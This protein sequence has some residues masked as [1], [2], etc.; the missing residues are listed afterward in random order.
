LIALGHCHDRG[1]YG[2][3]GAAAVQY[4]ARP[5]AFAVR[6][7]IARRLVEDIGV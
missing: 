3:E 6:S 2:V 1:G 5:T 7:G 4:T